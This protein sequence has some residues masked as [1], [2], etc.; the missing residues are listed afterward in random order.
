[1]PEGATLTLHYSQSLEG[2]SLLSSP[3]KLISFAGQDEPFDSSI[4]RGKQEKYKLGEGQ[5]IEGLEVKN[6]Y[7][8]VIQCA[9]FNWHPPEFAKCWCVSN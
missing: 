9:F 2:S 8:V 7:L 1:M 3:S 4:L 5:L 6:N